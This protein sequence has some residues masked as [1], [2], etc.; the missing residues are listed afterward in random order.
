MAPR[1]DIP[2]RSNAGRSVRL[3][4]IDT[5]DV[6]IDYTGKTFQLDAAATAG[7]SPV[8]SLSDGAGITINSLVNGDITLEF[9][10][11]IAAGTYSYD[12]LA[13]QVGSDPQTVCYG[14]ITVTAGITTP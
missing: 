10:D 9:P 1:I 12:L 6:A 2:L 4:I 14:T 7:G 5:N 11:G 8:V 13:L 3:N